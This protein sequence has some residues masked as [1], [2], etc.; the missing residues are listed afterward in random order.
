MSGKTDY[1]LYARPLHWAVKAAILVAIVVSCYL[2]FEFGRIQ[3]G[4]NVVDAV[5]E[6][7]SLEEII[8]DCPSVRRF[9]VGLAILVHR[10]PH[11]GGRHYTC[12]EQPQRGCILKPRVS[13][14]RATLGT[15]YFTSLKNPVKV[16]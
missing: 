3:S 4:F 8:R 6:K 15:G 12:Q 7:S 2:S 14:K 9:I 16:P 13:A 1:N 5:S 11:E 10:P